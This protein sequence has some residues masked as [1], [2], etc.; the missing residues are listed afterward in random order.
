MFSAHQ[1]PVEF[2]NQADVPTALEMHV[3]TSQV[4]EASGYLRVR[5]G[6]AQ[7]LEAG[8]GLSQTLLGHHQVQV[9]H[10]A[11]ADAGVESSR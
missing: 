2:H 5:L 9:P 8:C 7:G 3:D 11:K 1:G 4:V 10:G 6:V